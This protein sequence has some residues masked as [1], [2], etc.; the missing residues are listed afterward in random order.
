M[1]DREKKEYWEQEYKWQKEIESE[2][3]FSRWFFALFFGFLA[4]GLFACEPSNEYGPGCYD[5]DP[6]QYVDVYCE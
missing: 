5:A 6:T 2:K 3:R 1:T 4:I